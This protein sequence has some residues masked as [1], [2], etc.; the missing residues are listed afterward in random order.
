VRP[1]QAARWLDGALCGYLA[2]YSG[3]PAVPLAGPRI[4]RAIAVVILKIT[5]DSWRVI[6]SSDPGEQPPGVRW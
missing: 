3:V 2:G 6:S 4:G 1:C 5:G